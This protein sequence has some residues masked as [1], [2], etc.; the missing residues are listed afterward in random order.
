MT[1]NSLLGL[2]LWAYGLLCQGTFITE[3]LLIEEHAQLPWE[4][5][6]REKCEES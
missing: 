1:K 3:I 2:G 5:V 6:E 4:L